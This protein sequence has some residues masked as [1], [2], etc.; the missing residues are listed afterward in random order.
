[1]NRL[2]RSHGWVLVILA[3]M[4]VGLAACT[5]VQA[6]EANP[7]DEEAL[8][9][10]AVRTGDIII[11]ATGAGTVIPTSELALSFAGGG[12]LTELLVSVGDEVEAGEVL[13]RVDSTAAQEALA[14]AE[15]QLAQAVLQN[16]AAGTETGISFNDI[17]V[18]QALI[19]LEQAQADLNELLNW[20]PDE[21]EIALLQAQLEAA[22]AGYNAALGQQGQVSTSIQVSAISLEQAQR[23]LDDAQAAH[24]T[25]FDPGREWELNDPRRATALENERDAAERSLLRAQESLEV[26]QLNYNGTVSGSSSSN[27]ASSTATVLSA[28]QALAAAQEKPTDDEITAAETAVRKAQLA[29][30]QA[31]LNREADSL[32]QQQAELNVQSAQQTVNDTILIAP[33]GGVVTAVEAGVGELVGTSAIITLVDLNQPQLEVYLD[34]TDLDKVAIGYPADI[35][36]DAFPD[37]T[38]GGTVVAVDPAITTSNGVS[39]IRAVVQLDNS[40]PQV[41][42]VGLNATVDIV[43]GEALGATLVP[44]EALREIADGQY[45][46]FVLQDGEPVLTPVE[47][48]L[49]NFAFAEIISGLQP[50]Q[51]VTTGIVETQ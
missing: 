33:A 24:D 42:P 35:V 1:M 39:A 37:Q 19:N 15:L 12:R 44:I 46:V 30:Q 31:L 27:T 25:A 18:E 36:F 34:E 4:L 32:S 3:L 28:E 41:L 14:N 21:D 51:M 22:Q 7:A 50:G 8:Q 2:T 20:T 40:R 43:G 5:T 11:S 47:V 45:V 29:Y 13:A 48:G 9:T 10:T 17:A 23:D 26:A 38:I 49:M 16:E 6:D